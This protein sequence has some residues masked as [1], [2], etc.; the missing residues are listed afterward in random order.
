[1]SPDNDLAAWGADID[2]DGHD[3]VRRTDV[4]GHVPCLARNGASVM[5]QLREVSH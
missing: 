2:D 1:M 5:L 3:I 4:H